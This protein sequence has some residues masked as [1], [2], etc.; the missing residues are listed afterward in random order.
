M[1][2]PEDKAF[3]AKRSSVNSGSEGTGKNRYMKSA[4]LARRG[5]Q[6][7]ES[8]KDEEVFEIEGHSR[9]IAESKDEEELD[10]EQH[11]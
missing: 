4:T 1:S 9:S 11:L 3:S 7:F 6:A 5:L 2:K 8:G 10:F